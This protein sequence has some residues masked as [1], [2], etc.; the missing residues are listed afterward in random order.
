MVLFWASA[1]RGDVF[2]E[3]LGEGGEGREFF[4]YFLAV[5]FIL[6]PVFALFSCA[7]LWPTSVMTAHMTHSAVS[8]H[9]AP[10]HS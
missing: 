9:T 7:W 10:N 2:L 4:S 1:Q 8:Y 3:G 6:V 5:C